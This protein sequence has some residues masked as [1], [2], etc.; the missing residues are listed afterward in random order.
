MSFSQTH[1]YRT[2]SHS[3]QECL[4]DLEEN[5]I[6]KLYMS[7]LLIHKYVDNGIANSAA[8]C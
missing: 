4:T 8:F 2:G 3:G 6:K 5:L 7:Y 1:I